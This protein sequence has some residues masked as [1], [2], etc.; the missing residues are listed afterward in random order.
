MLE[1]AKQKKKW[2]KTEVENP[3][4]PNTAY[5]RSWQAQ[6]IQNTR[7]NSELLTRWTRADAGEYQ[8]NYEWFCSM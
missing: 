3:H 1:Q 6:Y 4:P 2:Q 7:R 5:S 8:M